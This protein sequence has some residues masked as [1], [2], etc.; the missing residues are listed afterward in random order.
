MGLGPLV[1][2]KTALPGHHS[3]ERSS[4]DSDLYRPEHSSAPGG[5]ASHPTL[6]A[7]GTSGVQRCGGRPDT[8]IGAHTAETPSDY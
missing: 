1:T 2:E 3:N 5:A 4:E 6:P 7:A 8:R